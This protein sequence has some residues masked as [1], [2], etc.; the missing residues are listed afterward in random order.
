M[1]GHLRLCLPPA[2]KGKRPYALHIGVRCVH[3]LL[4]V[5]ILLECILEERIMQ[6]LIV[7]RQ[8]PHLGS[9]LWKSR[10]GERDRKE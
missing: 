5:F 6:L 9:D 1:Y 7:Y 8:L 2:R 4:C 3:V 10:I